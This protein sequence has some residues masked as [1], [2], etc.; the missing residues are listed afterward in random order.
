MHRTVGPPVN[1]AVT[2]LAKHHIQ[3]TQASL[4]FSNS[5]SL[6]PVQTYQWLCYQRPCPTPHATAAIAHNQ[7]LIPSIVFHSHVD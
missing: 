6:P 5:Q 4:W 7:A 1:R 3:P 2:G